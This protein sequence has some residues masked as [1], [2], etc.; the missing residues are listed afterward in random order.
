MVPW[1]YTFRIDDLF[2]ND[3]ISFE[4]RRKAIVARM[5][6][7]PWFEAFETEEGIADD[8]ETETDVD[9]WDYLWNQFYDWCDENRVWVA[10][11]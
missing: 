11:F 8:L 2:H 5:R 10:T 9:E 7:Q 1:S 6:K 3:E 4:E